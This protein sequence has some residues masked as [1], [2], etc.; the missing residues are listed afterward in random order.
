M[1]RRATIL[2]ILA[3][4]LV[5]LAMPVVAQDA[6]TSEPVES[7]APAAPDAAQTLPPLPTAIPANGGPVVQGV[8]YFSQTCGYCHLVITEHLPGLYD[9]NGGKPVLTF[10]QSVLPG[11]PAFYLMNNGQLQ[12]LMVDV[13]QPDG[14]TLYLAD[15]EALG[16][17]QAPGVPL[18]HIG[19]EVYLGSGEIPDNLPRIV[20][21]GLASDGVAWPPIPGLQKALVPFLEDGSVTVPDPA[22]GDGET[23]VLPVGPDETALDR[24]GKDPVGNGIS[25]LVLIL[26]VFS[27]IAAPLLAIRGSLPAFPGWLVIVLV[28]IGIAAA[29]YLA[30][31][32]T[33]GG[34]AVCG[35][36]GDCNAVQESEY[37]SLFG[38]P[39]GVLGVVGYLFIGG[40]WVVAR[41]AKGSLADWALVLMAVTVFGGT[42]FSTYLTFLEPFVIGATC[43]WCIT[44]AVVMLALL[45]ITAGSG[46]A[47]WQ[48]LRG[49]TPT[50]ASSGP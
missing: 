24:I 27:L 29:V 20:E 38:I 49:S 18:L 23:V 4:L 7:A 39:I 37:A 9:A 35:P 5:L 17:G 16:F 32:E 11:E 34:E 12:L 43:M 41:V 2:L 50:S 21:D 25:I 42:L 28:A 13:S 40:L 6:A 3:A 48:R 30:S 45:W 36:V 47:A 44:S 26:L 15:S 19:D 10:D 1:R 22:S 31:I 46:W 8:F 14:Q 33:T